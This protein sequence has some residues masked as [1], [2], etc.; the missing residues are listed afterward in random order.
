MFADLVDYVRMVAELDPELVQARVSAALGAMAAAVERLGGTREKFIGDA[1]FAVFGWPLA[2]DDD[3]VRA[4]L[5][6]LS[7]R[8]A[9]AELDGDEPFEVR[10]GIATGEVAA[11]RGSGP[12]EDGRLTG[13]AI[14]T[15]AR[16]QSL[17]RPGEIVVDEAT[18]RAARNR[19]GVTDR[20][21][22]ILRGHPGSV[23]LYAVERESG[24][25]T[26]GPPR[27]SSSGPLVGRVAELR[28]L[29]DAIEACRSDGR[30]SVILLEGE[31]GIGK[32]RLFGEVE[33]LARAAGLGWTWSENV[34]YGAGEPYRFARV[35]AQALADEHGVDSGTFARRMLFTPD[36][37]PR[38]ARRY[39]GAIAAV[40]READF[41]GWEAEASHMPDD[42]AE[43]S[44]AL[45]E[46][47]RRYVDQVVATSGPR[48]VVVD[49]L[50][51]IDQ[52]SAAMVDL[53]VERAGALPLIL[54]VAQRPGPPPAWVA[55]PHVRRIRLGGLREPES[56]Q[57]A[58]NVARAALDA[59][60]A[61]Q[62]HERTG[63]NPLFVTET[64]RAFLADGTLSVQDGRLTLVEGAGSALPVTLRAVLGA[65]IDALGHGARALLGVASVVGMRFRPEM[66]ERLVDVEVGAEAVQELADSALIAPVDAETWRFG[67]ALIRDAA[68]SGL[69]ASR[70]R[71]LHGRVAD[72]LE[73]TL[74]APPIARIARHRAAAGDRERALPLL[75]EAARMALAV[76]AVN[77]AAAFWREAA[78]LSLDPVTAL[79]YRQ[80]ATDVLVGATT[81]G[82]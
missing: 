74:P 26:W 22:V 11:M 18:V 19:L 20:G 5:C 53:L 64:V 8:A 57:L 72:E 34:S 36:M 27:I 58:T 47:A 56:G 59:G 82:G 45:T 70:R 63:G 14:V 54:L 3:A 69:L 39:G 10:I 52:S 30:G 37:D 28:V 32:S 6:G 17:A 46:V 35:F 73:K 65:R 48:I 7:I 76:G 13:P 24:F 25:D 2:R 38:L 75:D 67:H 44:M 68:Y 55:E 78:E 51:W 49:D 61:R 77:E 43:V 15:A 12:L 40:A 4:A 80:Q 16:I 23:H 33:A 62:I 41:T 1:I 79:A 50:H 9:L 21:T 60:D 71:E 66:A 81:P 42:P 31:A 29:T